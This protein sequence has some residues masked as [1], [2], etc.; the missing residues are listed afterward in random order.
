[1]TSITG[2]D[3]AARPIPS[4]SAATDDAW[5]R[6]VQWSTLFDPKPVRTSFWEQVGLLVAALRGA[7]PCQRAG[8][9]RVADA[10][11]RAAG[12]RQR[13]LPRRLANTGEGSAGSIVKS[14]VFPTPSRR[15]S[16]S[17]SRCGCAT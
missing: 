14:A 8:T 17:V 5:Q 10:R 15:I 2:F 9:A 1:V 7:E 16:G 6:R 3:T 11:Q 13:L 4:S 12:L